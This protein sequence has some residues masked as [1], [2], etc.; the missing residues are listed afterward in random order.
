[1][2]TEE[3]PVRLNGR[4]AARW[5]RRTVE[6]LRRER[7]DINA[8]N[9]FPVPDGDTGSNLYHTVR[10]AY[11]AVESLSGSVTLPE[12]IGAMAT[13]ALRGAR[14]NSGLIL[15]V[16]LRG[17]AD[18]LEGVTVLD[19]PAFASA[20]ELA[21]LRAREAVADPVDGTMLT[22]LEAMAAE[23]RMRAEAGDTLIAQIEAVR[24]R[25]RGAL[26]ETTGQLDVLFEANI[27][28]AGSTGIVE[29]FDL[30]YLTVTGR[31]PTS[32]R[33]IAHDASAGV[34]LPVL[35]GGGHGDGEDA[36]ELVFHLAEEKDRTRPVKRLLAKA[37]GTSV[38]VS[39]PMVHVHVPDEEHALAV[40]T[41]CDAY[42]VSDLR[43]EDLSVTGGSD[44][45]S[46][47]IAFAGGVGLLF[48][49]GLQDALVLDSDHP[50][51]HERLTEL[52]ADA[53]SPVVVVP[54]SAAALKRVQAAHG[55]SEDVRIVR[56]R[57]VAAVLSALA[58]HDAAEDPRVIHA[59]MSEAA[60]ATRVGAVVQARTGSAGPLMFE[61]G[62]LLTVIDGRIRAVET[63]P[64]EAVVALAERLLGAGGEL[65]TVVTGARLPE[66]V[67]AALSAHLAHAHPEI[68]VETVHSLHPRGYAVLGVE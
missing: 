47:V 33:G 2:S 12:V 41:A 21:A 68:S 6:R 42:G 48:A 4:L 22:V 5:A 8:L 46:T 37:R 64:V 31:A 28:D 9:V 15:S 53:S 19:A 61:T 43:V 45:R 67:G 51:V 29:L 55:E 36:L 38:V 56:S 32:E 65:L 10:S 14:G 1:M 18:A 24:A 7:N 52:I 34:A 17:V 66:T 23:A 3:D 13:G 11:R 40:L 62:D 63:D 59:D 30:L 26:R 58:V 49:C 20:L 39:W 60:A 25:S 54:D 16:A 50:A 44:T 57:S 27:V 35:T